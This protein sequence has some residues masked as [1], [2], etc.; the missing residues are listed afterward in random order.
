MTDNQTPMQLSLPEPPAQ[1]PAQPTPPMPD[2]LHPG[3]PLDAA[4]AAWLAFRRREGLA[5]NTLKAFGA[6]IRIL[7]EYVGEQRPLGE[8]STRTLND[9]LEWMRFQ[10]GRPCSDKTYDR[11]VTGLKAF[12]RWASAAAELPRDPAAPVLNLSVRSP[13][14]QVMSELDV[15]LALSAARRL[16]VDGNALPPKK[17]GQRK[18]DQRPFMLYVLALHTGMKKS[19]FANLRTE[20]LHL[21]EAQPFLYVRYGD[22]RHKHKERKLR[23]PM[24]WVEAWPDYAEEHKISDY[25]FPWSVRRLEYLLADIMTVARLDQTISFDRLRWTCALRDFE[26]EMP[27]DQ[28]RRKLGVSDV[29]WSEVHKKLRLLAER[30]RALLEETL[31]D[32]G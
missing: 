24:M 18:P 3:T 13:L 2:G 11:R 12:F 28:L 15:Q 29:Q 6:D 8:I 23:L 5:E 4:L 31:A 1:R 22:S 30:R 32:G 19:E 14:P 27:P 16:R 9:Y 17:R 7:G 10:R 25:V 21:N 26:D 20:H